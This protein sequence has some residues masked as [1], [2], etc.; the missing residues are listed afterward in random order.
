MFCNVVVV[1]IVVVVSSMTIPF[2]EN[3]HWACES[4]SKSFRTESITKYTLTTINTRW[5]ATQRVTAAKLTRLTHKIAIELHLIVESYTICVL[6]SGSQS[7]NFWI[8]IHLFTCSLVV[9]FVIFSFAS[10]MYFIFLRSN[11]FIPLF[12]NTFIAYTRFS[13][14]YKTVNKIIILL[15]PS[16]LFLR[17]EGILRLFLRT[18]TS[19]LHMSVRPLFKIQT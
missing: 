9:N 3:S 13:Q 19:E 12:L 16:S 6:A 4:V 2:L 15:A 5:E 1:V 18:S 11:D 17:S 7:G 14:P 10:Y 8:D